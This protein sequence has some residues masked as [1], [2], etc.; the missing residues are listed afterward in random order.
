MKNELT[1]D[2]AA[3]MIA[4]WAALNLAKEKID[5]QLVELTAYPPSQ[6]QGQCEVLR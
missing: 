1:P 2:Q 4:A 3:E 6:M 5:Q